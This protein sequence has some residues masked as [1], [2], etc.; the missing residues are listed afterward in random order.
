MASM[1]HGEVLRLS[2]SLRKILKVTAGYAFAARKKL[3]LRGF[4]PNDQ[5]MVRGSEHVRHQ[6]H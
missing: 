1:T 2:L 6:A 3:R 4:L 5:V